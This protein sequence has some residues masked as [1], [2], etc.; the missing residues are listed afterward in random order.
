M[1]VNLKRQLTCISAIHYNELEPRLN[2]PLNNEERSFNIL[3]T[4]LARINVKFIEGDVSG[5]D[6]NFLNVGI[7]SLQN[8]EV[9]QLR[10]V[11]VKIWHQFPALRHGVCAFSP[12]LQEL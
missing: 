6:E 12:T 10:A 7:D 8:G 3:S 2:P 4:P 5:G 11:L 1:E 9:E